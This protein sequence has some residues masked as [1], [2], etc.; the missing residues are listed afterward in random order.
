MNEDFVHKVNNSNTESYDDLKHKITANRVDLFRGFKT[1]G[2]GNTSSNSK[3]SV[4]PPYMY[5]MILTYLC[6]LVV[7]CI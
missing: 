1:I 3:R 4:V 7:T 5:L 2:S 6:L